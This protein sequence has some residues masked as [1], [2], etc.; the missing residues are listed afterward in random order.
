MGIASCGDKVAAGGHIESVR[1][2]AE[3]CMAT[4]RHF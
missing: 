2:F 4:G 1:E 3:L